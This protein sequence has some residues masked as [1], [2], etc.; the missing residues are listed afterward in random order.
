MADF[1]ELLSQDSQDCTLLKT[2]T[3]GNNV[4]A[5]LSSAKVK[6]ADLTSSMLYTPA[7]TPESRQHFQSFLPFLAVA[8]PLLQHTKRAMYQAPIWVTSTEVQS[9]IPSPDEY[10]WRE[11]L[12]NVWI[13]LWLNVPEL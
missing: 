1:P 12:K 3:G 10:G 13:P 8:P 5:G 6:T 7:L 2:Q 11:Q 4:S 9:M